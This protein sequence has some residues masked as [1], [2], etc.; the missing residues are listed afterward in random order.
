MTVWEKINKTFTY[1]FAT[2]ENTIIIFFSPQILHNH[3]FR[4]LLGLRIVPQEKTMFVQ[5]IEG[6]KKIMVFSKVANCLSVS[7]VYG[8]EMK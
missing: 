8:Q 4:F 5:N 2:L 1:A 6:K 3:C 7:I